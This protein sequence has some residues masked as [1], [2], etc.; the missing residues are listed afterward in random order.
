MKKVYIY[1]AYERFWHWAQALI[2]FLLMATG[3]EV[4]GSYEFFGYKTAVEIHNAA[5]IAFIILTLFTIFWHMTTGE[6]KHYVPTSRK[7]KA[8]AMFYLL[9]IFNNAPHP[10][11]KTLMNKLNPLQRIVYFGLKVVLIPMLLITGG[12]YMFYRYSHEGQIEALNVT[13]LEAI[14]Y[15]HTIGAYLIIAFVVAHIYLT[16]TGHSVTSHLKAMLTGFE[17]LE[18]SE[19]NEDELD[20]IE[21]KDVKE[22]EL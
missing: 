7:L 15:L 22:D 3:F 19:I 8:Q 13:S 11:R 16:T 20:L 4:H 21:V 9:G 18:D 14:A 5:A 17:E 6:W 1:R 12:L 2:I 10:V